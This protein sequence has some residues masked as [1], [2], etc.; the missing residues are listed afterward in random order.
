MSCIKFALFLLLLL[1]QSTI[2]NL[3]Q[4]KEVQ[5]HDCYERGEEC[6][7]RRIK[8]HPTS[9]RASVLVLNFQANC[10]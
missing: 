1:L 8:N 4:L 5:G 9:S 7:G 10:L 6:L 3:A 2:N